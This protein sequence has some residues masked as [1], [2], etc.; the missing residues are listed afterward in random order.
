MNYHC[1][2]TLINLHDSMKKGFVVITKL[3]SELKFTNWK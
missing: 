3:M 1:G 2:I